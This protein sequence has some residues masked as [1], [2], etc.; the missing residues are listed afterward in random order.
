[1]DCGGDS[2]KGKGIKKFDMFGKPIGL[3]FLGEDTYKTIFG[4]WMSFVV[5]LLLLLFFSLR[6][7]KLLGQLDPDMTMQE[8]MKDMNGV[9]P[10]NLMDLK[11]QLGV[12]KPDPSIA[13]VVASQ[14]SNVGGTKTITEI[15]MRDC[16]E[17]FDELEAEGIP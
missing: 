2:V 9:P 5:G 15:E 13:R 8:T 16:K 14:V 10:L 12:S 6:T 7:L 4:G 1:M 11:F 17:L 3:T